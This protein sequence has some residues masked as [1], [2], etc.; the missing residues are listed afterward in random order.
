MTYSKL[1]EILNKYPNCFKTVKE[2]EEEFDRLVA[3][4]EKRPISFCRQG[5]RTN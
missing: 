2:K 4:I 5:N 3:S 1:K